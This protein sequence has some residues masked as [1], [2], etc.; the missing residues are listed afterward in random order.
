MV[1]IVL[2]VTYVPR[3]LTGGLGKKRLY[4][5]FGEAWGDDQAHVAEALGHCMIVYFDRKGY[6]LPLR[7]HAEVQ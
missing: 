3:D 7:V 5:T 2:D 6:G 1:N 4:M